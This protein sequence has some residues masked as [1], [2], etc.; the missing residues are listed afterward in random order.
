MIRVGSRSKRQ[1][2]RQRQKR[3]KK[4]INRRA[5]NGAA[6]ARE[7]ERL[8][9]AGYKTFNIL[10]HGAVSDLG[11]EIVLAKT[12]VVA[13]ASRVV[14]E[15]WAEASAVAAAETL[16]GTLSDARNESQLHDYQRRAAG[17]L[18]NRFRTN[19]PR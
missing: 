14:F 10:L 17:E 13:G 15:H 3:E 12:G 2:R 11:A 16:V 5:K 1:R 6:A 7:R 19:W 18:V 9:S 8:L 4:E